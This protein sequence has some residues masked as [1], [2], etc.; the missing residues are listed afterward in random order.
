MNTKNKEEFYTQAFE[1]MI[2]AD[3]HEKVFE[4]F[5]TVPEISSGEVEDY[6]TKKINQLRDG[7]E[8]D[9]LAG[10]MKIFVKYKLN[11]LLLSFATFTD[12]DDVRRL[13]M[14]Y[15]EL[16]SDQALLMFS[17][18]LT[19][20]KE[21]DFP[22]NFLDDAHSKYGLLQICQ[23]QGVEKTLREIA[24]EMGQATD[25]PIPASNLYEIGADH[26]HALVYNELD[27]IPMEYEFEIIKLI[28]PTNELGELQNRQVVIKNLLENIDKNT[29]PYIWGLLHN[30]LGQTLNALASDNLTREKAIE[31]NLTAL[32]VFTREKTPYLWAV[33]HQDL[34]ISYYERI[35]GDKSENIERA[36]ASFSSALSYITQDIDPDFYA[37]IRS[38]LASTY[39]D[40]IKGT[41][42]ENFL[43]AIMAIQEILS[44]PNVKERSE[45]YAGVQNNLSLAL[46]RL[47]LE[48]KDKDN[49]IEI[50]NQAITAG[51]IA[52]EIY[53]KE[54]NPSDWA[55]AQMNL[56]NAYR[57]R[58][59]NKDDTSNAIMAF[60]QSLD[61]YSPESYPV[62][63]S[64]SKM[65]LVNLY[66]ES[67][68]YQKALPISLELFETSPVTLYQFI[69]AT[70]TGMIF[71]AKSNFSKA[72][73]YLET[74]EKI[75]NTL[76]L[77]SITEDTRRYISEGPANVYEYLIGVCI[78]LGETA[79]AFEYVEAAKNR[80]FLEQVGIADLNFYPD[81][82][83]DN[84]LIEQ[85]EIL[86][87]Q[88]RE[89]EL[90]LG[91]NPTVSEQG[92]LVSRLEE[93][94]FDLNK[95]WSNLENDMPDY[96]TYRRGFTG[97]YQSA[98]Q[99]L[100]EN[101]Y[102]GAIVEYYVVFGEL[103]IFVI[104]KGEPTPYIINTGK[105]WNTLQ[106][107]IQEYYRSVSK[108][109]VDF[110]S[111]EA[112]NKLSDALIASVQPYLQDTEY[113]YFVPFSYLH[114][115]PFH[116]LRLDDGTFV[117]DRWLSSYTPSVATLKRALSKTG[118]E[119][120]S[121]KTNALIIGNPTT[122]SDNL[123]NAEA[124]SIAV[125]RLFDS[126]VYTKSQATKQLVVDQ[127]SG[128]SLLH[129]ACHGTFDISNPMES[130]LLF[131]D[132]QKLTANEIM[133]LNF[134]AATVILSACE[135]GLTRI[136]SGDEIFGLPRAFL[137][138]GASSL[139]ASLWKI[140]DKVTERLMVDFYKNLEGYSGFEPK[141][142][143][144]RDAMLKTK[145]ENSNPYFWG[146]FQL[147]GAS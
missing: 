32:D 37:E 74:A 133:N 70:Q 101:A 28:I 42:R 91:A 134:D 68:E 16:A 81:H 105:S 120:S 96:V 4:L 2:K 100:G 78:N 136:E 17:E 142:N 139:I 90:A 51:K 124:E 39:L 87:E 10:K 19:F 49:R 72:F 8:K 146:A 80:A 138:A 20:W 79:K 62:A 77:D 45:F 52:L 24:E 111:M 21:K 12:W 123:P 114:L 44:V 131:A 50:L 38:N 132:D 129:F 102:I 147:I 65:A 60:N 23:E 106:T 56:G 9:H 128:K 119:K 22:E 73:D 27:K 71:Y 53:A 117:I 110:T 57:I 59:L 145:K 92:K 83:H 58:N 122:S 94:K 86:L 97:D 112:W 84:K 75:L 30:L 89:N 99:V 26:P 93:I 125:A 107:Y 35:S 141:A 135:T 98:Q 41:P 55:M 127:S 5:S 33:V 40:R 14:S 82:F 113:I 67:K 46:Y 63:W 88:Y 61:I 115:L 118:N 116:A 144:L 48:A 29:T 85:E 13:L 66:T 47:S 54:H 25:V 121:F 7:D 31:A 69:G 36:I 3:G 126:V 95:V 130:F 143:A 6:F 104:R 43:E 109:P 18:M 137:Y 76:R 103:V 1:N 64:I 108:Y 11:F 140:D 15:P 34:G